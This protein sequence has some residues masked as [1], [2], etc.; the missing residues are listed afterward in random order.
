MSDDDLEQMFATARKAPPEP[1][2]DFLARVLSDAQALQ[3]AAA[4]LAVHPERKGVLAMLGAAVGAIGGWPAM[5]GLASAAVTGL[6]IGINPP[7]VLSTPISAAFGEAALLG[8]STD[9][10][11]GFDFTQFEG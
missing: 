11:E 6:W 1:S 5:A 7:N 9:F 4:P 3:S 10:G 8:E 2:P